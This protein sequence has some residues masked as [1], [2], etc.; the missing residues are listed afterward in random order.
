MIALDTNLPG[1][2]GVFL[3]LKLHLKDLGFNIVENSRYHGYFKALL[4]GQAERKLYLNLPYQV[5]QVDQDQPSVQI[6]F[7]SPQIIHHTDIQNSYSFQTFHH[8]P[9]LFDWKHKGE[10][11]V[12]Q[13]INH[14]DNNL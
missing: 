3:K 8:K 10:Q 2:Q 11:A 5:L 7:G 14:I 9:D 4:S 1:K 6:E 12:Q 13:I